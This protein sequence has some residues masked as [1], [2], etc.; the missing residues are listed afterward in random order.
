MVIVLLVNW[1]YIINSS[2]FRTLEFILRRLE[3]R[4][5]RYKR[6]RLFAGF[7]IGF[8]VI[9]VLFFEHWRF[10]CIDWRYFC[11]DTGENI[12]LQALKLC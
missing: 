2:N 4:L 9:A 12:Y 6:K 10:I 5:P 11:Q 8:T 7:E 1:V 3:V